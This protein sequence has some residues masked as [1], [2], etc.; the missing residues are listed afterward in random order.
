MKREDLIKKWLDNNLNPE[1]LE[2]F[3]KLED[4]NEL[5][6]I[7][8]ALQYFKADGFDSN[9]ELEKL[10]T[11][12]KQKRK[13]KN[14]WLKPI[15]RIAA[16]IAICVGFYFYNYNLDTNINT[17]F[18]QKENLNLP[19]NSQVK[20][21]AVS[22]IA[23][24]KSDWKT[25]RQLSLNGEAY[26]K[27]SKGE[28]FTVNTTSGSV[29]VLGTEFNIKN[30]DNI[31]EVTC[32]EGSVKVISDKHSQ[33]L[34]PGDRFLILNGNY[35]ENT[36]VSE[37]SPYWINNESAFKSMPYSQ[38]IA[39]FER[40]YNVSINVTNVNTNELFTGS[41]GHDNIDIALKAIALPLNLTY[42]KNSNKISLK[43]E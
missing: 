30:R 43:R 28:K 23:Y 8:T 37:K 1:E 4:Y 10:N 20:L 19:D 21:N 38:V 36:T 7:D 39:E 9:I 6:K 13:Q 5:I 22:T 27:V 34:K 25:E 14:T 29:T 3:K 11:T 32:Y 16:I 17:Q 2:A 40:Q 12:L 18:A 35:I 31:F 33:I 42:T 41:F 26:F 24:N 15:L